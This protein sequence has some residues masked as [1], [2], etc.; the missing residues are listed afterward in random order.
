MSSKKKTFRVSYEYTVPA[1]E[2][3]SINEEKRLVREGQEV[4]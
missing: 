2:A 1:D 4:L 3:G